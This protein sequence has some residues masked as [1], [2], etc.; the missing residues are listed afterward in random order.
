MRDLIELNLLRAS[1]LLCTMAVIK[2]LKGQTVVTV[3]CNIIYPD[4]LPPPP[5][6]PDPDVDTFRGHIQKVSVSVTLLD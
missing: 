1:I 6:D 2:T 3:V 5:P 4:P